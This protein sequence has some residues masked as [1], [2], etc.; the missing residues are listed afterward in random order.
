[1]AYIMATVVM[2]TVSATYHRVNWESPSARAWM[3][4]ADHSMIFVFIAGSYTPFALLALPAMPGEWCCR[5]CGVARSP[6][7]C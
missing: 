4:R 2:F 6:G 3:K 1:M 5:S 7:S